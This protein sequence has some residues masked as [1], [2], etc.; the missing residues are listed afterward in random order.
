MSHP[1]FCS[2]RHSAYDNIGRVAAQHFFEQIGY[3]FVPETEQYGAYDL[4]MQSPHGEFVHIEVEVTKAW[5]GRHFPYSCMSVPTRKSTSKADMFVKV[6]M[7]GNSILVCPMNR[8]KAAPIIRKDTT[9]SRNEP[10]YNV[11][12]TTI[13]SYY[14]EDGEWYT[15]DDESLTP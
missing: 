10:F 9:L 5:T 6:N 13:S 15:D 11:D 14:L 12:V 8:I 4:T 2:S 3:S 1:V 7:S